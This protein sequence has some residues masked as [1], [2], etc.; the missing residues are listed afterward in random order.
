MRGHSNYL[1]RCSHNPTIPPTR[2][3]RKKNFKSPV[4]ACNHLTSTWTHNADRDHQT[5]DQHTHKVNP[6][7]TRFDEPDFQSH[8]ITANRRAPTRA[9]RDDARHRDTHSKQHREHKNR[10]KMSAH[11]K[12][13]VLHNI[14]ASPPTPTAPSTAPFIYTPTQCEIK[15]KFTPAFR[16]N[17]CCDQRARVAL[18]ATAPA[19]RCE[20]RGQCSRSCLAAIEMAYKSTNV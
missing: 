6:M 19:K 4:R 8:I 12:W 13:A 20:L 15:F 5:N 10:R 9:T 1:S 2:N 11:K 16:S 18:S 14:L 3:A 7:T 17:A